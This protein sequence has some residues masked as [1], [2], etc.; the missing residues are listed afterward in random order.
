MTIHNFHINIINISA[1]RPLSPPRP[2]I[3][4]IRSRVISEIKFFSYKKKI[5]TFALKIS[6]SM[7]GCTF[8]FGFR[9]CAPFFSTICKA[10]LLQSV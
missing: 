2:Q 3:S 6:F 10:I 7:A 9:F 5:P 8:F 4:K 1:N